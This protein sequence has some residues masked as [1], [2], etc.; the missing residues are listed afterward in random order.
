MSSLNG[1]SKRNF[2]KIKQTIIMYNKVK[3]PADQNPKVSAIYA[4][5]DIDIKAPDEVAIYA[6]HQ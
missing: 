3:W 1:G 6:Y 4:L 5:N 2:G